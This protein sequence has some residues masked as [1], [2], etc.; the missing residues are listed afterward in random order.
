M[1]NIYI[2]CKVHIHLHR[3][4]VRFKDNFQSIGI[5]NA[6]AQRSLWKNK[7]KDQRPDF[8]IISFHCVNLET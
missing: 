8:Y 4:Q 3:K 6:N 1:K 5:L 7:N 2:F